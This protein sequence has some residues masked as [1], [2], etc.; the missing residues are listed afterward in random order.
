MPLLQERQQTAPAHGDMP[1]RPRAQRVLLVIDSASAAE[2][3]GKWIEGSRESLVG[4]EV[5]LLAALPKP[6]L[7]RTRALFADM[8]RRHL[9]GTGGSRLVPLQVML[10]SAGIASEDIVVLSD[11][12][13]SIVATAGQRGCDQIVITAAPECWLRKKLLSH[14]GIGASLAAQVADLADCPVLIIKHGWQ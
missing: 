1:M 12:A 3:I 10:D 5:V 11:D 14:T 4:A 7:I 2:T 9:R 8:V 13:A 6:E